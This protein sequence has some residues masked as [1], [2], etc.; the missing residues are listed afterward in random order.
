M[1]EIINEDYKYK[2]IAKKQINKIIYEWPE[3]MRFIDI[4]NDHKQ[5]NILELITK[6]EID[7][8]MR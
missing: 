5:Y 1:N 4:N 3:N 2:K 8:V 7:L 6:D